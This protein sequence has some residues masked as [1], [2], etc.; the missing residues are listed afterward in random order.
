MSSECR[1]MLALR[2][3]IAMLVGGMGAIAFIPDFAIAQVRP[4]TTLGTESSQITLDTIRGIESDRISGGARRGG[5]LFHSFEQFDIPEGRGAYFENPAEIQNIFSRVTGGDPSEINGTL[6]VIQEGSS[7]ILG[8]ANLFFINPN[9]IVFGQNARLDVG[10]SFAATTAEA[11]EFDGVRFSATNPEMPSQ[12]LVINPSAFLFN[13]VTAQPIVNQSRAGL[14]VLNDQNLLLLGGDINLDGGSLQ[15]PEGLIS[16]SSVAGNSSVSFSIA[17]FT[18]GFDNVQTF[19]NI[20]LSGFASVDVSGEGAGSIQVQAN[21]L[22][23]EERSSI[24]ANNQGREDGG[25]II[26]RARDRV[27]VDDSGILTLV[28]EEAS[29]KG[30]NVIVETTNLFVQTGISGGDF[31]LIAAGT[32]G[33]GDAGNL[34]VDAAQVDVINGGEISTSTLGTGNAGNLT[35]R[36]SERVNASGISP[37]G[38]FLSR[39]S[40]QVQREATGV[41]GDLLIETNQLRLENGAQVQAGT[42]GSGSGGSL[43]V[44]AA[45]SIDI[46]DINNDDQPAGLF[47]GPEGARASGNGGSITIRTNQLNLQGVDA[48]ISNEIDGFATGNT[49]NTFI[50]SNRINVSDGAQITALA[51]GTGQ[52]GSLT[53]NAAESISLSGTGDVGE[54]EEPSGIFTATF[55]VKDAGDLLL[56]TGQLRIADG[57]TISASTL[58]IG[59][60]TLSGTGRGGNLTI[61]V[62]DSIELVGRSRSGQYPSSITSEAGRL[63]GY[64]NPFSAAA[65]GDISVTA[66]QLSARDGAEI[67]TQTV[68]TGRA[69]NL[70]I[71]TSESLELIDSNLRTRTIGFGDAGNLTITADRLL[72]QGDTETAEIVASTREGQGRGGRLVINTSNSV[73]LVGRA[74][75]GT[76]SLLGGDAGDLSIQTGRLIVRDGAKISTSSLGT[77]QAG[78]LTITASRSVEVLGGRLAVGSELQDLIEDL[79]SNPSGSFD[80][81]ELVF[82]P[83]QIFSDATNVNDKPAG[84]LAIETNQLIIRGGAEVSANTSGNSAGGTLTVD[85]SELVEVSGASPGG[86][87]PSRLSVQT[88]GAGDAGDIRIETR[89]LNV[90]NRAVITAS[91]SV[92]AAGTSTSETGI[93]GR[94]GNIT[95]SNADTVSLSN[96]G[97][98][99]TAIEANVVTDDTTA[100]GGD[101]DI[102]T[103]QLSI[104]RDAEV[105]TSTSGQGNAGN[106]IIRDADTVLLSDGS[107]SAAVNME[108]VGQ[109]GD[110]N[111]HTRSLSLTNNAEISA[112]TAGQGNAGDIIVRNAETVSLS[113]SAIATEVQ[114]DSTGEGGLIEINTIDLNL[115]NRS[116]ISAQSLASGQAGDIEINATGLLRVNNSNILT[117]APQSS[118][119]AIA[120]NTAPNINP[121][122]ILLRNGDIRTQSLNNAGDIT[123]RADA[124][125]AFGDSDIITSSEDQRGG[126]ITL[127]TFFSETVPIDTEEPFDGDSRVD[128]NAEGQLSSGTI[129]TPDVSF[130]QNSLS[131]LP[132]TAIDTNTLLANSCIVP[133]RNLNQG[134]FII[135]GAGNLPERPGDTSVSA[136][137]TGTVQPVP[138][139]RAIS[140]PETNDNW[141]HGDPIIEPQGVYR[142]ADGRL[143]MSRHCSQSLN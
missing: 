22:H 24:F 102:Q 21:Q 16:L 126:N 137:P 18:L 34:I 4:D 125:I 122:R 142:L 103:R 89:R 139:D 62:S 118:G 135:T 42:L 32:L 106:I 2:F 109:G 117:A 35:I 49:G 5:N 53:I 58:G 113:N 71:N 3:G 84:N 47:T 143:I 31:G 63:I 80:P 69:G 93:S 114:E 28:L 105:T 20:Q 43:T 136:Y 29:G 44:N 40:T 65:G 60:T 85:A 127:D 110:V 52:G 79:I 12:L 13:Q 133:D 36:A 55:G 121:G 101:V 108:A 10:G 81:D 119:G 72:V 6:G 104:A 107:I 99:S 51:Y 77:G 54:N 131:E 90:Q 78:A 124:I 37:D 25:N 111:L 66:R 130:I 97:S 23:M 57:A 39:I 41:G 38:R 11:I 95:I 14:Q 15:A 76:V 86:N 123:L 50:E 9:G 17:D 98:I 138:S 116:S 46:F 75:V 74:G 115:A 68:G 94:P 128:V 59:E 30:G 83:S 61:E 82:S 26:I 73:E 8:N 64:P 112:S 129:T 48:Q 70:T 56:R 132:E 120:I 92:T 134:S 100:Q 19:G 140:D 91:A 33:E 96:H 141:Q 7:D 67:S 1:A 27:V 88:I 45:Q 87:N